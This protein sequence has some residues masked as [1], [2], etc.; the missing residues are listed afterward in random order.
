MIALI[1]VGIAAREVAQGFEER[2]A[3]AEIGADRHGV[4]RAGVGP[5]QGLAAGGGE[6]DQDGREQLDIGDDLHVAELPHIV[7]PALERAPANKDVG[8]ALQNPLACDHPG[9]VARVLAGAKVGLVH[10][11]AG[12]LDLQEEGVVATAALEQR[13]IDP[14]PHAADP[15]DLADQVNEREA[16]EEVAP[17][18]LQGH[19]VAGQAPGAQ[20]ILHRVG[21][22]DAQGRVLVDPGLAVDHLRELGKGAAVGAAL[23]LLLDVDRQ[24][25]TVGR[26]EVFDQALD[27]RPV[28]PEVELRHGRVA[29]HPVP[30]GLPGGDHGLIRL[31]RLE[32]ILPRRHHQA[33][34]K[35]QQVP[36]EGPGQGLVEVAQV[37]PKVALWGGPEAKVEDVSVAAE[38]HPQAAMGP[39]GEVRGHHRGRAT[40]IGPGRGDHAPVADGQQFG[41]P[42]QILGQDR[43]QRVVAAR[44]RV[45]LPLS[46]PW[47]LLARG[48]AGRA[49]LRQGLPEVAHRGRH[50]R[51]RRRVIS[52]HEGH[53]SKGLVA[54]GLGFQE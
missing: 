16:V 6:L 19:P 43:L 11:G 28:V 13:Q 20:R 26:G 48:L 22:A 46:V 35:A 15:H 44:R 14:H 37:E 29:G 41:N 50:R 49:S 45:P 51:D 32:A 3:F 39:G 38:L 10:R 1:L 33:G 42:D 9:A 4:S 52:C 36:F 24:L 27:V 25:A 18:L 31:A 40:E 23:G 30:V 5:G 53:S 47:C 8:R 7:V 17:I 21:D 2:R 12:L 54:A 34:G